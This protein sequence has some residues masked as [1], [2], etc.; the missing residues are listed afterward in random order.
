MKKEIFLKQFDSFDID[1]FFLAEN[2]EELDIEISRNTHWIDLDEKLLK[3]I[4]SVDIIDKLRLLRHNL[5]AHLDKIG[6]ES[7]YKYYSWF[8]EQACQFRFSIINSNHKNLPFGCHINIVNNE[9]EIVKSFLES[10]YHDGIPYDELIS[11]E[12]I[13]ENEKFELNVY[14][15]ELSFD[16]KYPQEHS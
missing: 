8:D 7:S 12:Y 15:E 13:D 16:Q 5:N 14:V 2:I 9:L 3:N 1:D 11:A 6:T 4:K 10:S